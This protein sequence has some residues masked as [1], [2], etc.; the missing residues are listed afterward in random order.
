[1]DCG[2]KMTRR[3]I[4]QDGTPFSDEEKRQRRNEKNK[5]WYLNNRDRALGRAKE[6]SRNHSEFELSQSCK[7]ICA[8]ILKE[9]GFKSPGQ[10]VDAVDSVMESERLKRQKAKIKEIRKEIYGF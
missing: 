5:L 10:V 9:N 1:M 2:A 7:L 3:L 4:H 6:R 8:Q